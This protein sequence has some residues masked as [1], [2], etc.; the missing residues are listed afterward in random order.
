MRQ[1]RVQLPSMIV[2]GLHARTS[3][4]AE[5]DPTRAQI[6]ATA[7][8]YFQDQWAEKIPH[9]KNPGTTYVYWL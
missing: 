1:T 9:R 8:R 2:V 6:G 7:Q 5:M 3:N 4:A